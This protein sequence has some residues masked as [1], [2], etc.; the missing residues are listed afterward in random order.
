MSDGTAE[1][2]VEDPGLHPG[3]PTFDV[4]LQQ[5][6]HLGGHDDQGVVDGGRAAGQAGPAPPGD[7][8]SAVPDRALH[9]VRDLLGRAREA[10]RD[11]SPPLGSR[12]AGVQRQLERFRARLPGA[13]SKYE[14]GD[15]R[16]QSW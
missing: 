5:T 3:D 12:I 10:H 7:E 6:V 9:R 15:E 2:E 13:E 14:V 4:D 16:L 8:R 1:V 11:G